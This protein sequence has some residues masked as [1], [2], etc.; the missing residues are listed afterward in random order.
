MST[1]AIKQAL[2]E[3]DQALE[4]RFEELAGENEKLST[5][6][7]ELSDR[8]AELEQKGSPG[9]DYRG[10]PEKVSLQK[11]L[12]HLISPRDNML[13]GKEAAW[14]EELSNKSEK[15]FPGA[16]WIPLQTKAGI[17]WGSSSPTSGAS[18][19]VPTSTLDLID[20]LR[21]ESV[22]LQQG[23]DPDPG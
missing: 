22:V 6:N 16:V 20:V 7:L 4:G 10:A 13:D 3:R 1:E 11:V 18:N 19:L 15:D 5:K 2:E 8:L 14:H 12:K 9:I 21:Q 17:D 23:G